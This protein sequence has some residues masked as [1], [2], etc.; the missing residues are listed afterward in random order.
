MPNDEL[1]FDDTF[2]TV[3][4]YINHSTTNDPANG[5]KDFADKCCKISHFNE[6]YDNS[7]FVDDLRKDSH[8]TMEVARNLNNA[9][10][11]TSNFNDDDY[12]SQ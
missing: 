9:D 7:D 8:F 6:V 12:F 11:D 2:S 3:D 1:I 10:P 5:I 4:S